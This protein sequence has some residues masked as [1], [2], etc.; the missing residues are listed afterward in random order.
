ML[1]LADDWVLGLR[2]RPTLFTPGW[3]S[4]CTEVASWDAPELRLCDK[5][6]GAVLPVGDVCPDSPALNF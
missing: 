3:Q 6:G 1:V 4:H 2:E 5:L